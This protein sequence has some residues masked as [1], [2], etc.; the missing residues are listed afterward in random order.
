MK[1]EIDMFSFSALSELT[2]NLKTR[3]K[4]TDEEKQKLYNAIMDVIDEFERYWAYDTLRTIEE[5]EQFLEDAIETEEIPYILA[6]TKVPYL[7]ICR[8]E[9]NSK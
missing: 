1:D 2:L 6:D 8:P 7:K 5:A 3:P 9:Q 4:L